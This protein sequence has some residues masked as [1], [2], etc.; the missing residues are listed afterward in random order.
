[1]SS[2][3]ASTPI[4]GLGYAHAA[5]QW[6]WFIAL[7]AV[8]L[9]AGVFALGDVV[10]ASLVSVI[11]IGAAMVVGGVFQIGHAFAT[12]K[13][14]GSFL[15]GLL[16]GAIYILGGSFVM[17]EPVQGSIVITLL[18]LVSLVAGGALRIVISLRHREMPGW[19]LMLLGG[20]ASVV[21]GI[22]LYS[23]L[24]WSGL[25]VLGMLI[26]IELVVQGV[27]WLQFGF[28]LRKMQR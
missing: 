5:S 3:S 16:S 17:R 13:S 2:S 1:M 22:L 9:G 19:W 12:K 6:R 26:G 21:V 7:G 8:M 18:I 10:L 25:W 11:I 14:W 15:F 24:P 27:T 20:L 4:N 23:A 28:A